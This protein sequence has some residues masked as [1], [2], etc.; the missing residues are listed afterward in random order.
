MDGWGEERMDGMNLL[1]VDFVCVLH[2]IPL[3]EC[4]Y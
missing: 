2:Y 3:H 1:R 4:M